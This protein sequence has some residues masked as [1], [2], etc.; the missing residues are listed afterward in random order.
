M[1]SVF[2]A[3][4]TAND[5]LPL[6]LGRFASLRE[7]LDYAA[8]GVTG[9]NFHDARG[10]LTAVLSY[11]E[12]RQRALALARHWRMLGFMAGERI[13]LIAET[14]PQFL[15]HFY[16]AQYAGL[17]AC[18]LP[19]RA[20][21][22][23]HAA[24]VAQLQQLLAGIGPRAVFAPR[25]VLAQVRAAATGM[26]VACMDD[27]DVEVIG[28]SGPST[29]PTVDADVPAYLQFSS[30]STAQ[31]KG[32]VVRQSALMHN[33]T[34]IAAHGL[35]MR[36]DDRACSWLPLY[37]DMGLVGF[38]VVALCGQRS[39]D[40]LP[41][42]AFAARPLAWLRLMSRCR[43][44]IVYAPAFAWRLAAQ[45]YRGEA[46]I[47]LSALRVAGVGGDMIQPEL[48]D[49]SAAALAP[50]GFR[51]EAF[52]PSYGM[53]EA[54]LAISMSA[55]GVGPRTEAAVED[56]AQPRTSKRYISC[57]APLPGIELRVEDE[58]G[59][60]LPER[61]AGR[62]WVRGPNV[63]RAY[64]SGHSDM[65]GEHPALRADGFLDTGDLGFVSGGEVFPT[66][67]AKELI[68]IR[69]RNLWPQDV[70]WL[71]ERLPGLAPGD[72]A[73]FAAADAQDEDALVLL[74]QHATG[75]EMLRAAVQTAV[76]EAFGVLARVVFVP[77]RSL[78]F[79]SSGKLARAHARARY[80]AGEWQPGACSAR[81]ARDLTDAEA[82]A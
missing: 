59:Q 13:A 18:P 19:C 29:L 77:P 51:R 50:T 52:Q 56:S 22:G 64:H 20:V 31:P 40:Y 10:A 49:A 74:I 71:I 63:L 21:A 62:L 80:L 38:S 53:A 27:T 47:D 67:R 55:P 26:T 58:H 9:L 42:M 30:G 72:V 45:R 81:E 69:G 43:T 11:T 54:T 35:R 3:T 68:I 41:P 12:L 61:A 82:P 17:V 6:R 60:V 7:A 4:P 24:Y 73:A 70:E 57:G 39:V 33:A 34:A 44:S 16:A 65:G 36:A 2:A 48:L 75:G 23:G 1:S 32:V 25:G 8:R 5:D 79:T 66:G 78:P 37:H 28:A 76:A 46:D 15:V 14:S